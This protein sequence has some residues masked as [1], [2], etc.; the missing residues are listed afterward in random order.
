[1]F[2][3]LEV[4]HWKEKETT[5]HT[6]LNSISTKPNLLWERLKLLKSI[7]SHTLL[8]GASIKSN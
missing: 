2:Y 6:R 5:F 3:I 7:Y 4:I 1:M 8:N